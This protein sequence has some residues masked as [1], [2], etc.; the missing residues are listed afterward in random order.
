[1]RRIEGLAAANPDRRAAFHCTLALAW[2]DGCVDIFEGR[3][4]GEWVWPP[5]GGNGFGYDPMFQPAGL[6]R[7]FAELTAAEKEQLSHRASAFKLLARTALP[8]C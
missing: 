3:T 5:R 8:A 1:M 2:P 6:A 4:E 7:S